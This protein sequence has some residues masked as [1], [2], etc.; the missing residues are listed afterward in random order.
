M[1]KKILFLLSVL[2]L[3][4]SNVYSQEEFKYEAPSIQQEGGWNLV[5]FPDPQAYTR[6]ARNQGIYDL[7]TAWI[8]ENVEKLNIKQ[9]VVVGDLVESNNLQH[10]DPQFATQTSKQMWE[11]TSRVLGRL[12]GVCPYVLCTGNHDY[13]PFIYPDGNHYGTRS[14]MNRETQFNA[15][16]PIDR[17]PAL[18]GVLFDTFENAYG[19]KSLENAAYQFEGTEGQR[20]VIVTLEFAPR[21]EALAWAKS[22]FERPENADAFGIIATHSYMRPYTSD[23]K[24]DLKENYGLNKDGG[25]AGE[26]IWEKLV[27]TTPNIRMVL[28]GHHST[29]DNM[30]G[31]TGYR[32]DKNEAGKDVYQLVCDMQAMGGGWEGNGGDGWLQLMEFSKDMKTIKVRTFSPFFAISPTTQKYAWYHGDNQEFEINVE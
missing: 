4:A 15:Y 10:G 16:F 30:D 5:L 29:A 9:V 25:N 32:V 19:Y 2:V 12:D 7:M 21:D 3:M 11:C 28:C 27:K 22:V 8:S 1:F 23:C 17:N 20:V 31:C 26:G 14:S 6:Y 24:R 13:G 18:R